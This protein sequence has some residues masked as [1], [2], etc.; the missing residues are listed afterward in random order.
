M[1][2]DVVAGAERVSA[3]RVM[4]FDSSLQSGRS[5]LEA[6]KAGKAGKALLLLML[7]AG[8][9]V[10]AVAAGVPMWSIVEP[11]TEAAELN[12]LL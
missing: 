3:A 1:A 4:C 8:T 7:G 5:S 2:A 6:G 9:A 12:P 11:R 10:A